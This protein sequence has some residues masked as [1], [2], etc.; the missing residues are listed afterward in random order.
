[1]YGREPVLPIDVKY[2]TIAVADVQEFDAEYVRKVD[3][4]M[5][6]IRRTVTSSAHTNIKRAQ[7]K[8][9]ESYNKRHSSAHKY[10]VGDKVLLRNLRRDDRKGDKCKNPWLGPYEICNLYDNNTCTLSTGN[11]ILK[12][13]QHLCNIKPFYERQQE[14]AGHG[15]ASSGEEVS[16]SD[17][18][19]ADL[20]LT[21]RDKEELLKN[22]MLSDKVIDAAQTLLKRKFNVDGLDTT[23]LYQASGF[24]SST[25]QC[26]QIHYDESRKH[27][28]TSSTVRNRVELA[29]SLFNGSLSESLACQLRQRYRSFAF[30]NQLSVFVLPVLQQTNGVDCGVHA[31]ATATE[32]LLE[33]GDVLKHFDGP[34]MR[35]HLVMCLEQGEIEAFPRSAKKARGRK[36]KIVEMKLAIV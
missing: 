24:D 1:M 20:H 23:L 35:Q 3:A 21:L 32:F 19:I 13:K 16:E 8:Q 34:N 33:D 9:A 6:S 2:N 5:S 36:P 31:I 26:V 25:F 15:D 27:W 30:N 10:Q 11:C 29:D 17:A 7:E 28:I 14:D 4:V 18:W 12:T 22:K